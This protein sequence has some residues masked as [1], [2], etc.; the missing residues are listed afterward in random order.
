MMR[1][2]IAAALIAVGL[3]V[4]GWGFSILLSENS[5]FLPWVG[6][7]LITVGLALVVAGVAWLVVWS[8]MR[9]GSNRV[10]D[11]Q[12]AAPT[13][14]ESQTPQTREATKLIERGAAA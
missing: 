3:A 13:L 12:A 9:I 4:A 11:T 1:Q 5:P 7:S 8:L 2:G 6:P 10:T 14:P